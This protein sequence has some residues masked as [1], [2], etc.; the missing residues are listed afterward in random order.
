MTVVF[1][2]KQLVALLNGDVVS[3]IILP[4][5]FLQCKKCDTFILPQHAAA[6]HRMCGR[7][8]LMICCHVLD[9]GARDTCC[10][11][12]GSDLDFHFLRV[13]E[14]NDYSY[15]W[16]CMNHFPEHCQDSEKHKIWPRACNCSLLLENPQLVKEAVDRR[17]QRIYYIQDS[18]QR[19]REIDCAK[20]R[21]KYGW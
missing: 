18:R 19:Q 1:I 16:F 9:E 12:R 17:Q 11:G 21:R 2:E 3:H 6:R 15:L 14:K 10:N 5:L 13:G 8:L 7:C 4:Y 20:R